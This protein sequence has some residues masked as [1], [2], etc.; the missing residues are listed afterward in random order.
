MPNLNQ[1]RQQLTQLLQTAPDDPEAFVRAWGYLQEEIR[2]MARGVMNREEK[3][4]LLETEVLINEAFISL[5]KRFND[6]RT[7]ELNDREHFL[8]TVSKYMQ[9]FVVDHARSRSAKKR[10]GGRRRVDLEITVG[11]LVEPEKFMSGEAADALEALD[12][13]EKNGEEGRQAAEIARLRW[14]YGW[15]VA[16]VASDLEISERTVKARWQFAKAWLRMNIEESEKQ[17]PDHDGS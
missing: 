4:T 14:M 6:G 8:C 3:R 15:S 9:H 1:T 7:P 16:Q 11:E 17:D 12:Q 10:G 5:L 13:L 2:Y